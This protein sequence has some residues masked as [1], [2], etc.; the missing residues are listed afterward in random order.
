MTGSLERLEFRTIHR[1]DQEGSMEQFAW[2]EQV[3]NLRAML[4]TVEAKL[5]NGNRG[6]SGL[7]E[8]KSALDDL[9]LRAWGMLMAASS[10]DPH[11]FQEQFRTRRGTE[12]CRALSSDVRSGKLSGR[13]SDLP[14]LSA[15]AGD[16]AA[17]VKELTRKPAKRRSQGPKP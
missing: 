13:H 7:D 11:G 5:A 17:A 4:D 6:A 3:A 12:M 15:A 8:F 10:D 9:R 2:L 1:R 16:L 14:G